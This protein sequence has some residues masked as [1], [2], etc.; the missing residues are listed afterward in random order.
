[1]PPAGTSVRLFAWLPLSEKTP[2]WP[3]SWA[4]FSLLWMYPHRN[5][6]ANSHLLGQPNTLLALAPRCVCTCAVS[7]WPS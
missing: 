4:N 6:W 2:S 7:P 3:R 5:V 1:M